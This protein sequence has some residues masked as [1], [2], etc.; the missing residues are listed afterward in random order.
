[1]EHFVRD[2]MGHLEI[3]ER[4]HFESKDLGV[5]ELI[6]AVKG[7]LFIRAKQ[8][9]EFKDTNCESFVSF[10]CVS[11]LCVSSLQAF[12]LLPIDSFIR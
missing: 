5:P 10:V 3:A 4:R 2:T 11:P 9:H 8:W 12:L 1:M 6:I 7:M